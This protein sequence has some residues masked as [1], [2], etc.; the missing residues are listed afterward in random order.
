MGGGQ[1]LLGGLGLGRFGLVDNLRLILRGQ[2]LIDIG[3]LNRMVNI[4]VGVGG[5]GQ[6]RQLA[7]VADSGGHLSA[8]L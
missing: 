5:V 4:L 3:I 2:F 7:G 1:G 8:L 6:V